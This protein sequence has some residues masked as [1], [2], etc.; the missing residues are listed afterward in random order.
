MKPRQT[1]VC[2]ASFGARLSDT[3]QNH[4]DNR[5]FHTCA[6]VR[7][8]A[9]VQ[10]AADGRRT[11]PID[12]AAFVEHNEVHERG[13]AVGVTHGTELRGIACRS[14]QTLAG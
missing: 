14:R 6:L 4:L 12:N 9:P 10:R 5:I 3:R 11:Q 2:S 13:V 1:T 8:T 7:I